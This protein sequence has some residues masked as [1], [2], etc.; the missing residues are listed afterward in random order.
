[1]SAQKYNITLLI[2]SCAFVDSDRKTGFRGKSP[3]LLAS[4]RIK[5]Q[6]Q[7]ANK[8]TQWEKKI[9]KNKIAKS[10]WEKWIW[11][12][13]CCSGWMIWFLLLLLLLLNLALWVDAHN[14]MPVSG[15]IWISGTK[16]RHFP[17]FHPNIHNQER[18]SP[19]SISGEGLIDGTT[20]SHTEKRIVFG[21]RHCYSARF[22]SPVTRLYH[23]TPLWNPLSI[24]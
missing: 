5:K 14:P 2:L 12:K 18:A 10:L 23:S 19:F 24:H 6:Q 22:I 16:C 20:I 4:K 1:M 17:R 21:C 8:S 15:P 11:F 7:P 9:C 3:R 13:D